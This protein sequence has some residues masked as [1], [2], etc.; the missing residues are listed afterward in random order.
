MSSL[1]TTPEFEVKAAC[2]EILIRWGI[3]LPANAEEEEYVKQDCKNNAPFN[4]LALHVNYFPD[5]L[6]RTAVDTIGTIRFCD[7]MFTLPNRCY[8][9]MRE[10][11]ELIYQ[12][13][14]QAKMPEMPPHL[15]AD[16]IVV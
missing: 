1:I 7:M 8:E 4:I 12:G 15:F 3:I 14:F 2:R 16:D 6:Q 5:Q 13:G 11:I 9:F 10:C